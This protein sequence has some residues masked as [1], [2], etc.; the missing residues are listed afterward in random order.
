MLVLDQESLKCM[1]N[2]LTR[3]LLLDLNIKGYLLNIYIIEYPEAL[4][5]PQQLLIDLLLVNSQLKI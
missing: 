5:H 3:L 4:D 1:Y 2:K